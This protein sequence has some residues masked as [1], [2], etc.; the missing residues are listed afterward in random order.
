MGLSQASRPWSD[1]CVRADA[2]VARLLTGSACA[3][4]SRLWPGPPVALPG[5][6][7]N[8][9]LVDSWFPLARTLE[10]GPR[11]T[12]SRR[13]LFLVSPVLRERRVLSWEATRRFL[14]RLGPPL[15]PVR[16]KSCPFPAQGL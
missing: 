6:S 16:P 12:S 8:L 7:V 10:W 5:L 15:I 3:G 2:L 1:I 14:Y 13:S 11:P 9:S 4:R